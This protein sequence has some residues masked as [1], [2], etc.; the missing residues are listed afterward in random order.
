MIISHATI[1]NVSLIVLVWLYDCLDS[2]QDRY[3]LRHDENKWLS[4]FV[5]SEKENI[6]IHFLDFFYLYRFK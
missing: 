4:S 6:H 5:L 2:I 1:C 3:Q